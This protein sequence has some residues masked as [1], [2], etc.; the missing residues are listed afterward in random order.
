ML[1]NEMTNLLGIEEEVDFQWERDEN[2]A[3]AIIHGCYPKAPLDVLNKAVMVD[4]DN[5]RTDEENIE[6]CKYLE[7]YV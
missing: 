5:N 6:T 3:L 7:E 1:L 2:Y 4:W